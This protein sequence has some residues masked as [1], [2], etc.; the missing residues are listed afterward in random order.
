MFAI[1]SSY[2]NVIYLHKGQS[3]SSIGNL[4]WFWLSLSMLFSLFAPKYL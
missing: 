3:L 4:S 2:L 1:Y